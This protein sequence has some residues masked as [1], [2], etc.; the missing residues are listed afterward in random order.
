V[1][2]LL[3]FFAPQPIER[4]ALLRIGIPIAILGF[5]AARFVHVDHLLTAVGFQVPNLGRVDYR[6]PLYLAP[7]SVGE[8]RALAAITV[9]TGLSVAAGFLMRVAAPLFAFALAYTLR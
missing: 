3:P 5:F 8:A 6:Q 2:P 1:N 9:V 4:L 7:L